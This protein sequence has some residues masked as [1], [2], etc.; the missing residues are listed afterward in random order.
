MGQRPGTLEEGTAA[1]EWHPPA[2]LLCCIRACPY[3]TPKLDNEGSLLGG[4]GEHAASEDSLSWSC[5]AKAWDRGKASM[6]LNRA[7]PVAPGSY[8]W[9]VSVPFIHRPMGRGSGALTWWESF[10]VAKVA[11][12]RRAEWGGARRGSPYPS[13]SRQKEKERRE[14]GVGGGSGS[15]DLQNPPPP[16]PP[17]SPSR[18]AWTVSSRTG[19][20]DTPPFFFFFFFSCQRLS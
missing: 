10:E 2:P 7:R 19:P 6:A 13:L 16:P 12:H 3:P 1:W 11:W 8:F 5:R 14:E 9:S 20:D 15:T 4:S 18:E 17:G